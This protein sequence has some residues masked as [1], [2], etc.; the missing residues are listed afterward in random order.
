MKTVI[1]LPFRGQKKHSD[2]EVVEGLQRRD[3]KMEEWFYDTACK[4]YDAHFNE[5]FFDK[6]KKQEIFQTAFLKLWTEI[7]NGKIRNIEGHVCRQQRNGAYA[8]MTCS[9]T[10]F[11]ITFAKNEYRELVRSNHLDTEINILD[12]TRMT[13]EVLTTFDIDEDADAK[14]DRIVDDCIQALSPSC[15]EILTLFYYEGKNLDEILLLRS[16]KN[17]SKDGLKTAK[18]KCMTTLR[19]KVMEEFKKASL[20]IA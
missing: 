4:Y 7:E 14:K 2:I 20:N 18:N 15:V 11:L 6:D 5:I 10:T 8:S 16:D 19:S 9:L 12:S 13:D 1:A 17:S 3:R